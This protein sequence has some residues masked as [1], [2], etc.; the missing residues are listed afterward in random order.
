[1]GS[2]TQSAQEEP[3]DWL[4]PPP[5]QDRT[6]TLKEVTAGLHQQLYISRA[7]RSEKNKIRRSAIG[8]VT[9]VVIPED[10]DEDTKKSPNL[11]E[12][13]A[14]CCLLCREY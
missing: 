5:N 1:M 8:K 14:V 13:A 11:W 12:E 7:G 3:P 4:E 2:V 10:T 9:P 6:H